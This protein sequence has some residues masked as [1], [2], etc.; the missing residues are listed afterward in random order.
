[1]TTLEDYNCSTVF[2]FGVNAKELD[3]LNSI[4]SSEVIVQGV[5]WKVNCKKENN[6]FNCGEKSDMDAYW[7]YEVDATFKLLSLSPVDNAHN[8]QENYIRF[9]SYCSIMGPQQD[10]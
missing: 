8:F 2:L 1:M 6:C 5:R 3:L 7:L 9:S 4:Y 10:S